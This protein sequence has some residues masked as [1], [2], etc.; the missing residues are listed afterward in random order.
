MGAMRESGNLVWA[1]WQRGLDQRVPSKQEGPFV[2]IG[3]G[4]FL[5]LGVFWLEPARSNQEIIW[6]EL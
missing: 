6:P 1:I 2:I 5:F 4:V 3:E